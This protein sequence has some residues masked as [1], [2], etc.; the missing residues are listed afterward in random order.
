MASKSGKW[1]TEKLMRVFSDPGINAE[2][3]WQS[4]QRARDC[5]H[6]SDVENENELGKNDALKVNLEKS[7]SPAFS[8]S[9]HKLL[10][11]TVY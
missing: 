6:I 8:S 3:R 11:L 4:L 2:G 1:E 10:I 5:E 7:S 9:P